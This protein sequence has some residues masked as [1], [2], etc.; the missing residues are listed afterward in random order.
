[1]GLFPRTRQEIPTADLWQLLEAQLPS[2]GELAYFY[3]TISH[4]DKKEKKKTTHPF[5]LDCVLRIIATNIDWS[6]GTRLNLKM[7]DWNPSWGSLAEIAA[8]LWHVSM[9]KLICENCEINILTLRTI[10][11]QARL[12]HTASLGSVVNAGF[13]P[14]APHCRVF[15]W[16]SLSLLPICFQPLGKCV[17]FF[18]F[19]CRTFLFSRVFNLERLS[20][21]PLAWVQTFGFPSSCTSL[22]QEAGSETFPDKC[23][24]LGK[25]R[26]ENVLES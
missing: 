11:R 25:N 4:L 17:R 24:H 15:W 2:T 1:M 14:R 5:H 16:C 19:L 3:I 8:Y 23:F 10:W 18:T 13:C 26:E 12:E 21:W 6:L 22:M 20:R 9:F 7:A